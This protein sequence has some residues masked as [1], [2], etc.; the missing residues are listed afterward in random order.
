MGYT[1]NVDFLLAVAKGQIAGHTLVR[2]FGVNPDVDTAGEED[3][4]ANG[5]DLPWFTSAQ[6]LEVVS[7]SAND[8]LLGT[9][10]RTLR[11]RGLSSSFVEQTETV[12]MLGAVP[13]NLTLTYI[14]DV[15]AELL[16]TGSGETNDGDIDIR[17]QTAGAVVSR[18][19]TG[20]GRYMQAS[21]FVPASKTGYLIGWRSSLYK[22]TAGS[23]EMRLMIADDGVGWRVSKLQELTQS[24]NS[25]S[26]WAE[27]ELLMALPAKTRLRVRAKTSADN[28]G[29]AS[30]LALVLVDN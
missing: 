8:T 27:S 29:V 2:R 3:V 20:F 4:W 22:A 28:M 30:E 25:D 12:S 21:Y 11:V 14:G 26:S 17:V 18:M 5:G 6:S 23:V 1:P 7:G 13:V 16:T 10:A 9:G 15:R 24:G 19:P